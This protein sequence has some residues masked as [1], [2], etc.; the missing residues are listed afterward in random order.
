VRRRESAVAR[1][2]L[3]RSAVVDVD[4]PEEVAGV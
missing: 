1:L 2:S 3:T 4:G